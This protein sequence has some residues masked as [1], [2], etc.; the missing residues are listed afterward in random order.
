MDWIAL[1]NNK[2]N[3]LV[4]GPATLFLLLGLGVYLTVRTG[5]FQ[6]THFKTM[7][8][9][10]IGD[11]GKPRRFEKNGVSPFQAVSTALAGTLGTGNIVG[12]ATAIAAGG[13]GAV[14]W[15]WVSSFFGMITKY[16]EVLLAVHYREEKN[17]TL[18]GGPMYYIEKGLN[19]KVLANIFCIF[20]ALA[21]FGI[22]SMV[23]TNS[24][25]EALYGGFGISRFVTAVVF[26]ILSAFVI[27]GGVKRIGSITEKIVPFMALCYT[28]FTIAAL[29]CNFNRIDD[30]FAMIFSSAFS[31]RSVVSGGVGYA[32]SQAIRYGISRGVFS[33]EAGLG[34]A[35]IAHA[36]AD[37]ESPVEQGFW[38]MFEV[39]FDTIVMCTLTALVI[40]TSDAFFIMPGSP[41][42]TLDAFSQTI[43]NFSKQFI[44]VS[45]A[46][47]AFA[48]V[49]GWA[50]YGERA[51]EY[52]FGN[53]FINIYRIV[54]VIS[55][56]VGAICQVGI[57]WEISDTLNGLM[58]IPNLAAIIIL[59]PKII[60]I[61]NRYKSVE[62]II[63][64]IEF[65][66]K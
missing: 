38:G 5:F 34:S 62:K 61:T 28:A 37:T 64:T 57:V 20:C 30:A 33:N 25:S 15:M 53:R 55:A 54:Y 6:L 21:S 43:G 2:I 14:F 63:K 1:F 50:Y 65:K 26:T 48:S 18:C 24:A 56:G 45:M 3:G 32:V 19:S 8:K 23:Q 29:I 52:L 49:V 4:W 59:S 47:F 9:K 58:V 40:L 44:A 11:L 17:G 31:F 35:P 7:F 39:F 66:A 12:V 27:I 16:G 36:A 22:G 41:T 42:L 13:P 10:T 51:V 46:F 60:S